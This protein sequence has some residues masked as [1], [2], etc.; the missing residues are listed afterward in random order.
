MVKRMG[1]SMKTL[2][3]VL[4]VAVICVA[5]SPVRPKIDLSDSAY[6]AAA[7]A[8]SGSR[9]I[10]NLEIRSTA[11]EGKIVRSFPDT[12]IPIK[13]AI[14]TS[15][16]VEADLIKFFADVTT[17]DLSASRSLSITITKADCYWL[18]G[19][20]MAIPVVGLFA[21]G[22]DTDFGMHLR[23]LIEVE[24][25]GKVISTYPV[26]EKIVIQGKA[27]TQDSIVESYKKL[28]AEYR[29]RVFGELE[30]RFVSRY[31]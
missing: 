31:L 21:I 25:N 9:K 14:T 24:E 23:L 30:I 20:A 11:E 19:G 29:K 18:Y 27:T 3:I 12:Y 2:G 13:T 17:A 8:T 16:T 7:S 10:S 22:A 28:M 6:K 26:D 15:K 5:C 4:M 1:H